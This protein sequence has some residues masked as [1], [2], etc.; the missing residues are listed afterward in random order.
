MSIFAAEPATLPA[1]VIKNTQV[2]LQN[3]RGLGMSIM[4]M[5]HIGKEFTSIVQKDE[6]DMC[7]LLSI[8]ANYEILFP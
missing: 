3:W 4:E 7:E 5:V 2:E 6:S 1:N 8:P